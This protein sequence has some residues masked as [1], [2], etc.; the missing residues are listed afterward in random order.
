MAAYTLKKQSAS[1]VFGE[2]M[3]FSGHLEFRTPIQMMHLT[4]REII[5]SGFFFPVSVNKCLLFFLC[6]CLESYIIPDF[7]QKHIQ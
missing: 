1:P 2:R 4:L 6:Q 5:L 7:R 3:I